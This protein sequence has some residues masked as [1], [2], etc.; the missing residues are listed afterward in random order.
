MAFRR[1]SCSSGGLALSDTVIYF[2]LESKCDS[3]FIYFIDN[4][5]TYFSSDLTFDLMHPAW[6]HFHRNK[7]M[8]RL[9]L[10]R[11]MYIVYMYLLNYV[12]G[13]FTW[14]ISVSSLVGPIRPTLRNKFF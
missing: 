13:K 4:N 9:R 8:V 14:R 5:N 11:M 2:S 12:T 3:F 1:K 10:W 6:D 7:L